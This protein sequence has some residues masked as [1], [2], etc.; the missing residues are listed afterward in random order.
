MGENL[1]LMQALY[2]T[3][4]SMLMVFLILLLISGVLSLFK[5]IFK[6][7]NEVKTP[8]INNRCNGS[9][10]HIEDN[11]VDSFDIDEEEKIVVALAA[12][13]M[14]GDGIPNPNLHIKKITRIS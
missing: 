5:Y 2:I 8:P 3:V 6:N 10:E 12:S 1:S 7:E 4:S 14:L 13:I 9:I 11:D